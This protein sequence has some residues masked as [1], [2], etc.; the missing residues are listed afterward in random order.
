MTITDQAVTASADAAGRAVITITPYR[1]QVWTVTQVSVEAPTAPGSATA[2]LQKGS[3]LV[4]PLVPSA[5]AAAGDPPVILRPGENLSV[6]W[7]GMNPGDHVRAL[8]VY[9]DGS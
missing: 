5:D 2:A 1:R 9:D 7:Q 4:T 6:V 8:F 3:Y